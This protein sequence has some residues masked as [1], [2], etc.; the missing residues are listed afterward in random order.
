MFL[1]ISCHCWNSSGVEHSHAQTLQKKGEALKCNVRLHRFG[2]R[3]AMT[4][5]QDERDK[6]WN[7]RM[8]MA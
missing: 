1:A 4:L 3:V 2:F 6:S 5:N 8:E 7:L